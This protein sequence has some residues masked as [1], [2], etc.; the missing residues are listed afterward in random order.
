MTPRLRSRNFT[1]FPPIS[2]KLPF[3]LLVPAL[4]CCRSSSG[5]GFGGKVIKNIV[6]FNNNVVVLRNLQK[7]TRQ[8]TLHLSNWY[9]RELD[10]HNLYAVGLAQRNCTR[11]TVLGSVNSSLRWMGASVVVLS[12]KITFLSFTNRQ[13]SSVCVFI[14]TG[15][16]NPR[17]LCEVF[18]LSVVVV[19]TLLSTT[20]CCVIYQRS[21]W[22]LRWHLHSVDHCDDW[23]LTVTVHEIDHLR[24][25][26]W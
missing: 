2:A 26:W 25:E 1:N 17:L 5:G 20:T 4:S 12:H 19:T 24:M 22:E 15:S 18:S 16:N 8:N 3:C 13:I 14:P 23:H 11:T 6:T 9:L 7:P 21:E 10:S